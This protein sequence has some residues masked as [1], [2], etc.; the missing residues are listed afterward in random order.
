MPIRL[1]GMQSGLDTEAL[2]SALVMGYR[3]KKEDYEK[4]QTKLSWKQDKWK[5]INTKITNFYTGT[6]A[7]NKLTSAYNLK[8]AT[9]NNSSYATVS[10]STSAVSGT[11]TLKVTKLASTGYLTGGKISGS[12]KAKLTGSSKL[13]EVDGM[14]SVADGASISVTADGKTSTID[15]SSDMTINQFVSKLKNAGLTASFDENNQRF[16]ISSKSSGADND[17]SMTAANNNGKNALGALKLQ[18]T[19]ADTVA[20]DIAKYQTIAGTDKNT[21]IA[22]TA[23]SNYDAT[24]EQ[25]NTAI[26]KLKTS[27][28]ELEEKNKKLA[29]QKQ[30]VDS[31]IEKAN[32]TGTGDGIYNPTTL[33]DARKYLSD[34]ESELEAKKTDGT[35]TDDEKLELEA[36]KTVSKTVSDDTLVFTRT[37]KTD[38]DGNVSYTSDV[39]S[40]LTSTEASITS[41]NETIAA[42][43]TSINQYYT[44]AGVDSTNA[45]QVDSTNG[46]I[47]LSYS[48]AITGNNSLATGYQA[49][50]TTRYEY[51]VSM[52][53]AYNAYTAGT[54]TDSQK[55][56]LGLSTSSSTD[57]TSAVRIAGSNAQ[58]ELNG[59]VFENT[60]NN[61]SINGLTI[62]ATALTGNEAVTIT[63]DTDVD[64]IYDTIKD[65]F[66]E[67]NEL[68][69]TLDTA[70]N[71]DSAKG[72]EP[73]TD[74]EK[75]SMSDDEIEKW[76]TKIKDS[77]LRNDGT[78]SSVVSSMKNSMLAGITIDGKTYSLSD[79]GIS[80]GSYFSTSTNEKGVYHIDGDE[81]DSTSK[82]NTDKLKAAIANDSD[83][84]IKFFSQLANNLY[85]T[86]NKKLGTSNSMSSYMS[87]YNDKEMATQYSEYKT[88]ISDQETKI[89]TWEDYYYKK[90]SRMESALASLN[91]QASSISGLFG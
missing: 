86:L 39:D 29:Y 89:S 53:E 74:D 26:E 40:L 87:I 51:A 77:L 14:G 17:F 76:E 5:T 79:F 45:A 42:N 54:A 38:D 25:Y 2:V 43:N 34:R 68:I 24:I 21:Y 63:T 36:V 58:I 35:I 31:F 78:L 83:T 33:D 7:S 70:L 4:A 85:S 1:S 65:M 81:D 27:N 32:Y 41:N 62:Q 82:G 12:N 69:K 30:Y 6:L 61:F 23:K 19:T 15:L 47:L 20:K 91:S 60:T 16:F 64:G 3:T 9:I 48:D 84:V 71:A 59:A 80:T 22:D 44:E 8:K 72:Y 55:E 49:A 28:A 88:K 67:Y 11:Q 50:A 18:A 13:S 37:Q 90:F 66:S 57:T 75:E 46:K 52:V 10:A 56:L 73:L